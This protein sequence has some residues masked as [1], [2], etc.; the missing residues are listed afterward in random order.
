M[1][2]PYAR[3]SL[4]VLALT[5]AFAQTGFD[6]VSIKPRRRCAER[7]IRSPTSGGTN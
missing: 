5:A 4:V 7:L 2:T 6:V 3:F 1:K